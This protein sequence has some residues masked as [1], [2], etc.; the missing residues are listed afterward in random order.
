MD[1]RLGIKHLKYQKI[2]HVLL[3]RTIFNYKIE[4]KRKYF[5]SQALVADHL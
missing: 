5:E 3:R 1:K 4:S 2:S